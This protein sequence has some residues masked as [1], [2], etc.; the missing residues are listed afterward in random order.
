[1]LELQKLRDSQA[2][3]RS[4]RREKMIAK[5][6]TRRGKHAGPVSVEEVELEVEEA[7]REQ[8]GRTEDM[9]L[10]CSAVVTIC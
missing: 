8:V 4:Q 3:S 10:M 7:L 1:M 5:L 9:W 2:A 6:H